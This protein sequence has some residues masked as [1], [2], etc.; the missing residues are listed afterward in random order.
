MVRTNYLW[1]ELLWYCAQNNE[2]MLAVYI[3]LSCDSFSRSYSSTSG[4]HEFMVIGA[5]FRYEVDEV[6]LRKSRNSSTAGFEPARAKPN[7]FQVCLL[8]HSDISTL[9]RALLSSRFN[10]M[11]VRHCLFKIDFWFTWDHVIHDNVT[12]MDLIRNMKQRGARLKSSQIWIIM[13]SIQCGLE[14]W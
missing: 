13:E 11:L 9:L 7:R 10:N 1:S 14:M 6:C 4:N 5:R 12:V 3:L 8:N 2:I